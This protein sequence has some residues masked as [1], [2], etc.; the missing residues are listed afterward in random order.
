MKYPNSLNLNNSFIPWQPSSWPEP[1]TI[2]NNEFKQILERIFYESLLNEI[3]NVIND[4]PTLEHRGHVVAL[5]ILCAI[6]VL[7]SYA[8][9]NLSAIRCLTCSRSDNVSPRYKKYIEEFFPTEYKQYATRIYKLYRNSITHS[10]NLFQA[11]MLPGNEQIRENNGVII[12]GLKN[13]FEALISSTNAYLTELEINEE[14]QTA[15]LIRYRKLK[16]SA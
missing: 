6:D 2:F 7:S 13:F 11:A 1:P 5:S 14:L 16:R 12:L 4:A 3:K 15:S 8:F 10:W 9:V